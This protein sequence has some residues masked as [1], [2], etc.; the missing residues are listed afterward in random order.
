MSKREYDFIAFPTL[1]NVLELIKVRALDRW[2]VHSF[3]QSRDSSMWVALME[4]EVD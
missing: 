3:C 1:A 4:R 2:V